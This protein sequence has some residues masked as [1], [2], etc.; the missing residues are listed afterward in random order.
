V[1]LLATP[2]VLVLMTVAGSPE[3]EVEA[4]SRSAL[5][6]FGGTGMTEEERLSSALCSSAG[7]RFGGCR[8]F[9]RGRRPRRYPSQ[10][11]AASAAQGWLW[12]CDGAMRFAALW[13]LVLMTVIGSSGGGG[14]GGTQVGSV[15]LRRH[16][17]D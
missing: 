7:A 5:R 4:V 16:R 3:V 10:I 12:R 9:V 11:C 13:V 14:Q 8:R 6:G 15:R 17:G 1:M 2:R